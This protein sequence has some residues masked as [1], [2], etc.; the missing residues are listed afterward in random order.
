VKARQ[1][2]EASRNGTLPKL[3]QANEKNIEETIEKMLNVI[4]KRAEED[5]NPPKETPKKQ[6]PI[7]IIPE[8]RKPE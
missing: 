6:Y 4:K 7:A 1:F 3:S 8:S 5:K 2:L